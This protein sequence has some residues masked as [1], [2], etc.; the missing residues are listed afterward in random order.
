MAE[1]VSFKIENFKGIKSQK[2]DLNYRSKTPITTLVG[3]NES[4]KTTVLEALSKFAFTDSSQSKFIESTLGK[5]EIISYIP[6]NRK[7]AFT[8]EISVSAVIHLDDELIEKLVSI[9]DKRG[10]IVDRDSISKEIFVSTKF[11]FRDSEFQ[12]SHTTWS[13]IDWKYRSKNAKRFNTLVPSTEE[14]RALW[15]NM[16]LRV[17]LCL[18][19]IV[20]FP[21]F[22]VDLP[23]KIYLLPDDNET[24]SNRYYRNLISNI[25]EDLPE[26]IDVDR[27]VLDRV[28]KFKEID[29]TAN[30]PN[31]I[32]SSTQGEAIKAC[33]NKASSHLSRK[34][35][36]AWKEVIGNKSSIDKVVLDWDVDT[37][38][39]Q[40]LPY[41]SFKVEANDDT[42]R[43]DERSLG[44]RWFFSFLLFTEFGGSPNRKCIFL[45]DEPA[46]N[47]HVKAQTQL[48]NSLRALAE[49]GNHIIYSTHS[50]HMIDLSWL[51]GVSIVENEAVDFEND[52]GT[53]LETT[54]TSI[55]LTPYKQFIG[56]YPHRISY[57][58]P[59]LEKL[60][61]ESPSISIDKPAV[62]VEGPSDF[63]LLESVKRQ[64]HY[65]FD[66]VPAESAGKCGPLIGWYLAKGCQFLLLLDDDKTGRRERDRYLNDWRLPSNVVLTLGD[67]DAKFQNFKLEDLLSTDTLE[68]IKSEYANKSNKKV[69]L[70]YFSAS[71]HNKARFRISDETTNDVKQILD[72]IEAKLSK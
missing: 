47:L 45:F 58:Q 30:W 10:K 50:A 37:A 14:T 7:A 19:N 42:Y 11:Q 18:P 54:P 24:Q 25:F 62:I 61:Y 53:T 12:K 34:I 36:K 60:K 64:Y 1:I 41:V 20:Y 29:G 6:I 17:R 22:L 38:N 67:I 28:E 16:V 39:D 5:K 33:F 48:L 69:I 4:G 68:L 71:L 66:I 52:D 9:F 49:N 26:E 55:K 21:T 57:F 44:F 63:Y 46:A 51:A 15:N 31:R 43:V 65:S 2:I 56:E 3:L 8:D 72:H 70:D 59:I 27:H 13:G 40:N 32:R 35:T 23:E